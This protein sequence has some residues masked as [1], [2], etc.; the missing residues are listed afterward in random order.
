LEKKKEKRKKEKDKKEEE[1][2]RKKRGRVCCQT[3]LVYNTLP[4]ERLVW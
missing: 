2:G 4:S 3:H 1:E